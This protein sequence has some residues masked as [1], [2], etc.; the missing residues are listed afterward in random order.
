MPSYTFNQITSKAKV[1]NVKMS[2]AGCGPCS[3][4]A[5]AHNLRPEKDLH[6]TVFKYMA[7]KGY[8]PAGSTRQGMSETITHMGM[9]WTFYDNGSNYKK[10]VEEV[11]K[12]G[13][14]IILVH[15]PNG[16]PP[17]DCSHFTM[18]GHYLAITSIRK[19]SKN[20]GSYDFWVRDSGQR[21]RQGWHNTNAELKKSY[22]SGWAITFPGA[23]NDLLKNST[24]SEP[25]QKPTVSVNY[26]P[27]CSSSETSIVSALL[28]INEDFV[29]G[30]RAKIAEKN[31]I[32][33]YKGTAAQ[34]NLLL[35]KLKEGTLIRP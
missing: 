17:R 3:I 15:G 7:N 12:T 2:V 35:K 29:Y 23:V 26:F 30:Y 28:H 20:D 33:G 10:W 1:G 4:G 22:I 25:V 32:T 18:G 14:G 27:K 34:N 16:N 5:I 13:Y 9:R 11:C 31:G 24:A 8:M 6:E 21:Q 19:S